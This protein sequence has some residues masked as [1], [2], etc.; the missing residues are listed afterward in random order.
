[1][2]GVSGHA[3]AVQFA[4]VIGYRGWGWVAADPGDADCGTSSKCTCDP[5]AEE[6]GSGRHGGVAVIEAVAGLVTL[7][8]GR[9]PPGLTRQR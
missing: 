5:L 7:E 2:D 6:A 4:Q 8:I 1:M 9:P 3:G